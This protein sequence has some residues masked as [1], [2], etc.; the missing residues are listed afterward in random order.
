MIQKWM[1]LTLLFLL[2]GCNSKTFFD[3]P[4]SYLDDF[5]SY[6]NAE[7][8]LDGNDQ[9]WSFFQLTF[10]EN[11]IAI[12]TSI[13]HS[14]GKSLKIFAAASTEEKGASKA[15]IRKQKMAFWEGDIV[16]L[17]AWYFIVG[18][19]KADWLF[20]LDLE[21]STAIGAGPGMRLAL[22]DDAIALEH[23]FPNPNIFQDKGQEII[24]PR[25]TWVKIRFET[26]LSKRKKGYVKVW[27]DDVLIIE[28]HNW[29]TLPK[30]ILYFVQGSK[31]GYDGVEF[32][33]T[34]NTKDNAMTVYVD[35][36]KI[37][38]IP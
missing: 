9:K 29:K 21:E 26:L 8:L 12:D 36:L 22:V 31:G 1:V 27:Q 16:A 37:G 2:V 28:K 32:G 30:D 13:F 14:G 18:Q 24:F 23:K 34:A 33:I 3:G 20:L 6:A 19:D 17:E 38:V 35:D 5:E 25:D 11:L 15:S 7:E 10:D 4:N